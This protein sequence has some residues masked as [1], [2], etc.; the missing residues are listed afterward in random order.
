[1][2]ITS[3]ADERERIKDEMIKIFENLDELLTIKK[4]LKKDNNNLYEIHKSEKGI[5]YVVDLAGAAI[6]RIEDV[7]EYVGE[8]YS[9]ILGRKPKYYL[10]LLGHIFNR[11]RKEAKNLHTFG[12]LLGNMGKNNLKNRIISSLSIDSYIPCEVDISLVKG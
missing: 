2:T 6:K 8:L 11:E 5:D 7:S 1:M 9:P 12:S 10:K 3:I 4:N